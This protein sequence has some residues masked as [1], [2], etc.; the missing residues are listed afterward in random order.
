MSNVLTRNVKLRE[1]ALRILISETGLDA[2]K[3]RNLLKQ[4]GER[5]PLAI[6]MHRSGCDF[7]RSEQAL[8]EADGVI[9]KA[10]AIL[11]Q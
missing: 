8:A 1:R 4:A 7:A 10:L 5:L 6:L 2:E 3:A 9:E 11:K